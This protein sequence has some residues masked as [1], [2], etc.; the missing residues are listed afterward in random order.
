[1][2]R[3]LL[4]LLPVDLLAYVSLLVVEAV[5]TSLGEEGEAAA[6]SR[7]PLPRGGRGGSSRLSVVLLLPDRS[8]RPPPPPSVPPP[9]T[10]ESRGSFLLAIARRPS[11]TVGQQ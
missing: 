10:S 5:V 7:P 3:E 11:L 2:D 4:A 9:L 6:V 1:M 8:H